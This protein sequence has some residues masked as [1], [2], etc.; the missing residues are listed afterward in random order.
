MIVRF[1]TVLILLFASTGVQAVSL[2]AS[3]DDA[4]QSYAK[5]PGAMTTDPSWQPYSAFLKTD[6]A[7]FWYSLKIM[8]RHDAGEIVSNPLAL[9]VRLNGVYDF[10][11]DD[12]LIGS[13]KYQGKSANQFSRVLIPVTGLSE[14]EHQLKIHV[15]ALGMRAGES[16][17]LRVSVAA[18]RSN[19]FGVHPTVVSTFFIA[20]AALFL[21]AYLIVVRRAGRQ[22][23]GTT[24]AIFLSIAIS[25]A[26]LLEEGRHFFAYPY[27]WQ[28]IL[29]ALQP[30]FALLFFALLPWFILTRINVPNR[31]WW[32]AIAPISVALSLIEI[33][34]VEQH[35]RAFFIVSVALFIV[36]LVGWRRGNDT[37]RFF[38]IGLGIA[39]VALLL[40][41]Y[42]GHFFLIVI[43]V[44]VASDLALDIQRQSKDA[45]RLQIMS[46]RLRADLIKRNVQPHFL[47]NSLTA[48]MEWVETSPN[49]AVNFIDGLAREFR[50]LADFSDRRSVSLKEE[51]ALCAIHVDLMGQRLDSRMTLETI[52]VNPE[53]QVPPALFHTLIEN[54]FSHNDYR[55][56]QATLTLTQTA[57]KEGDMFCLTVPVVGARESNQNVG[58]GT[59]YIEARLEE[60][61]GNAFS[62][63]SQMIGSN[64][65][66][67]I[68][69]KKG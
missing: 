17:D 33:D 53:Q 9:S 43:T 16:S 15:S 14:G 26:V 38:A 48:L 5:S 7:Q 47:M 68:T 19:F 55:G 67:E 13:N 1:Y 65:V 24:A 20:T 30:P 27:S 41:P 8:V 63:Q 45:V 4:R 69:F 37:A 44:M 64:W 52:D 50:I 46:E 22:R 6:E 56:L 62:F 57:T 39:L 32:M 66:S 61:C 35:I 34:A 42:K 29:D 3:G 2:I 12:D 18:V 31:L 54:A 49:D 11:W 23:P 21:A 59:R 25:L 51:L 36:S 40:D 58:L 10:Y 28:P 60:F